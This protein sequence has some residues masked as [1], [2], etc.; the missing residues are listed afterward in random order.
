MENFLKSGFSEGRQKFLPSQS[1]RT[2]FGIRPTHF[3]ALTSDARRL[4]LSGHPCRKNL[5]SCRQHLP[6]IALKTQ[7]PNPHPRKADSMSTSR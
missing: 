2:Y 4:H 1:Y 7:H 5:K 6:M 3:P